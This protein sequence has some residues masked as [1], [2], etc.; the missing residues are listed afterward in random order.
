MITNIVYN[1]PTFGKL[2]SSPLKPLVASVIAI[3]IGKEWTHFTKCLDF[4]INLIISLP[5]TVKH[6]HYYKL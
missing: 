2:V 4:V 6:T 1:L 5:L 3:S